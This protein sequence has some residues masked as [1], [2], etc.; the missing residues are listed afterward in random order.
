VKRSEKVPEKDRP[1]GNPL[2]V[3]DILLYPNL[4]EPVSKTAKEVAFYF[5]AYPAAGGPAAES[6]I[7]L[8]QNG[9]P[10]AQ[11]PMPLGAPD[12][13]GRVQQV[14]RLP[15]SELPAGTY[16]L[17]AIVKQGSEQIVRSTLLRVVD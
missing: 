6:V 2:L 13:A 16:D 1:V 7:E 11:I 4:S 5:A 9:K 17:R 8:Q 14:G 10:V 3:K 15:I 12:A